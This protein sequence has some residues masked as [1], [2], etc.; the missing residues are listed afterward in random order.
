MILTLTGDWERDNALRLCD[1]YHAFTAICIMYN[2]LPIQSNLLRVKWDNSILEYNS[3]LRGSFDQARA[4]FP[5]KGMRKAA[6][7]ADVHKESKMELL[8]NVHGVKVVKSLS[9]RSSPNLL[10]AIR[11]GKNRVFARV[12]ARACTII[13]F[14]IVEH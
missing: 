1:V 12:A 3:S 7:H 6:Q 11:N 9:A 14:T 2:K 5:F 8:G 13:S 10:I 4:N